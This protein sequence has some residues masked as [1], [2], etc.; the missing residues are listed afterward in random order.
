MRAAF[1]FLKCGILPLKVDGRHLHASPSACLER[2]VVVGAGLENT[3]RSSR[4]SACESRHAA[5]CDTVLELRT[6]R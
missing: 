4:S 3:A 2:D 1:A 5:D 6:W